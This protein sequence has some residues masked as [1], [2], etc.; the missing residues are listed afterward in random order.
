MLDKSFFQNIKIIVF[1]LDGTIVNLNVNWT[2]LKELLKKRYYEIYNENCEFKRI[3]DCLNKIVEKKDEKEL[4]NFFKF[5]QNFELKTINKTQP[6][7]EIIYLIKNKEKFFISPDM[8]LVILSLNTRKTIIKALKLFDIF[9]EFSYI[10][11]KEDVRKWK[12]DPQGLLKIKEHFNVGNHEIIYFGDKEKDLLTGK[13]A[14]IQSYFIYDL[15]D[16]VK[17]N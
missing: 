3:S 6:I 1:D 2:Y 16:F 5:I 15:I 13:N 8:K 7:E 17:S 4:L 11:G 10:I 9:E 12:P 14:N